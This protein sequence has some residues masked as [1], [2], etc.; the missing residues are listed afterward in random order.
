MKLNNIFAFILT[1]TIVVYT[2]CQNINSFRFKSSV[3]TN[4]ESESSQ[5]KKLYK[6]TINSFA[7]DQP[8]SQRSISH[9]EST[10]S[11]EPDKLIMRIDN[12]EKSL[13]YEE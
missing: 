1:L 5:E 7:E 2:Y 8:S 3:T 13:F 10:I 11:M 6:V 12:I 9:E 4:T